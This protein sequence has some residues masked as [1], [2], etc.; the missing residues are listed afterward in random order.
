[1]ITISNCFLN[2]EERVRKHGCLAG[3]RNTFRMS[4][5]AK[6]SLHCRTVQL[7]MLTRMTLSIKKR[8]TYISCFKLTKWEGCITFIIIRQKE[9]A[10]LHETKPYF[11]DCS[12]L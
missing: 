10:L 1:M 9:G 6:K 4:T 5:A 7:L 11:S 12:F 3:G 8:L 2:E